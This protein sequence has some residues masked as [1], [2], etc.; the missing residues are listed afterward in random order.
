MPESSSI[1]PI[2][3]VEILDIKSGDVTFCDVTLFLENALQTTFTCLAESLIE[4]AI[5]PEVSLDTEGQLEG[6]GFFTLS[7]ASCAFIT[8]YY[9]DRDEVELDLDVFANI[10]KL[11]PSQIQAALISLY[12]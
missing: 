6:I 5:S 7:G 8:V 1:A 2:Y 9:L 11:P 4:T 10:A 12:Q 3:L